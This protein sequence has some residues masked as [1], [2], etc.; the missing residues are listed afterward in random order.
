MIR[1]RDGLPED[2]AALAAID[3]S[4][5]NDRVLLLEVTGDAP[6]HTITLR[7]ERTKSP[8]SRRWIDSDPRDV[9]EEVASAERC[10]VAELHGRLAGFLTL[11]RAD[12]HPT[13]GFIQTIAVDRSCRSQGVASELLRVMKR[14]A[15][16]QSLR[17]VFWEAQTDNFEAIHFALRRGFVFTGFNDANYRNDDRAR[18][19]ELDFRGIALFLY[20]I[21]DD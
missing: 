15:H 19:R 16:D 12:W 5:A 2:G 8:D 6:Q 21:T 11:N 14:Y 18:Q 9:A 7:W 1:I 13:T 4:F 10:W 20:W 17:G 3:D